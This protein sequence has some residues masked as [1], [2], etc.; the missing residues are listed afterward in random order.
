MLIEQG[1]IRT[2]DGITQQ[3]Y[4]LPLST[5]QSPIPFFKHSSHKKGIFDY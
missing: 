5:T 1:R 3:I 2:Y 4:N